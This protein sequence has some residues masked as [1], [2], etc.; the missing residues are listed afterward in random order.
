[1]LSLAPLLSGIIIALIVLLSSSPTPMGPPTA[2][3]IGQRKR[4]NFLPRFPSENPSWFAWRWA[5]RMRN[6]GQS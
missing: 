2:A 4:E 1:H 6:P 3:S 5:N